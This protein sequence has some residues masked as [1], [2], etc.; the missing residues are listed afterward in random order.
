MRADK[1]L[2][3]G[4]AGR[5][6]DRFGDIDGEK[7]GVRNEPIDRVDPDVVRVDVVWFAPAELS[8]RGVSGLPDRGRFRTDRQVLAIRLVPNRR[9]VC[10]CCRSALASAELGFGLAG[11]TIA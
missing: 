8:A 4:M 10:A 2:N 5:V 11:E 3:A 6:A 1:L 7:V 9:N